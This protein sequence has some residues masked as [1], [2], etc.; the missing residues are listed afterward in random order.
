M[1]DETYKMLRQIA[2]E[3]REPALTMGRTALALEGVTKAVGF[4]VSEVHLQGDVS[5]AKRAEYAA[6]L[7]VAADAI[8][9]N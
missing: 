1:N 7:R 9:R 4:L 3:I 5:L 8:E 2:R 6:A